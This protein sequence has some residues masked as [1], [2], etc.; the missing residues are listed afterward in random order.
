MTTYLANVSLALAALIFILLF[1]PFFHHKVATS[2]DQ[3]ATGYVIIIIFF[4]HLVLLGLISVA[5]IVIGRNGYFDWVSGNGLLRTLIISIG[6][7]SCVIISA[8]SFMS[9][10]APGSTPVL[11]QSMARIAPI[12][13]LIIVVGTGFIL[14]NNFLRE[15]IPSVFYKWPLLIL[16][17]GCFAGIV[18]LAFTILSSTRSG[19]QEATRKYESEKSIKNSRLAEIESADVSNDMVRLLEFTGGLYPQEVREQASAKIMT[20][21]SWQKDLIDLME[22]DHALEVFNFLQSNEVNDKN[23]FLKP[24]YD[25]VIDAAAW[26]RHM[27]QGTSPSEF[28]SD[29]FSDEINRVLRTVE[30]FEGMGVDYL[31]AVSEV[32]A[33]LDE[34]RSD[35]KVKFDCIPV[36]DGWISSR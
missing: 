16:D 10:I 24:V 5:Y 22:D 21:T 18:I 36:L 9:R 1:L 7:L 11:M 33:A 13:I 2:N 20:D 28:Y 12:A 26:I 31:P 35:Q 6:L 23:L 27:I 17:V 29:M 8:L 34:P 25:G 19:V 15:S 32:R 14:N 3:G 30:K 4:L